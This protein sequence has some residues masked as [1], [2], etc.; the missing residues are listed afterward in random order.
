M[1]K[2]IFFLL[3]LCMVFALTS[4]LAVEDDAVCPVSG[5]AHNYTRADFS[6]PNLKHPTCCEGGYIV[7]VCECGERVTREA[8]AL[9]HKVEDL[10]LESVA[11]T[12]TKDG[13]DKYFCKT[14]GKLVTENKLYAKGHVWGQCHEIEATCCTNGS[15]E[16]R[17]E[18]CDTILEIE[19]L[20]KTGNHADT[21]TE[22]T[23]ATCTA[24][25]REIVKCKEFGT[26]LSDTKL[27]KLGHNYVVTSEGAPTCE[28]E[29]WV[30]S[31]CT[32][33]GD[34]QTILTKRDGHTPEWT[35]TKQPTCTDKG[36]EKLVCT[37]PECKKVLETREL[38][39]LGHDWVLQP[40]GKPA[41]CNK[42]GF[43][44]YVCAVCEARKIDK[45]PML[46]HVYGV[47]HTQDAT[48]TEP[49]FK[50][51][52]CPLCNTEFQ[53]IDLP[54]TE[55]NWQDVI[56]LPA[57]CT[58]DGKKNIVCKDCE[59]VKAVNVTIDKLGHVWNEEAYENE[60]TC[61]EPY[62]KYV[63]C[64]RENCNAINVLE[65]NDPLGH[66]VTWKTIHEP[67][68]SEKGYEEGTCNRCKQLVAGRLIDTVAHNFETI[69]SPATSIEHGADTNICLNCGYR[70]HTLLHFAGEWE[71]VAEP[72][73]TAEGKE[74]RAI[75]V[76]D[77][78][79]ETGS[80]TRAIAKVAHDFAKTEEGTVAPTCTEAGT[81]MFKCA[82]CDATK[83]EPIAATGHTK[84][85]AVV[86]T[87]PTCT[88]KG[89]ETVSCTV[90]KAA[91]STA[92]V[93]ATGHT[94]A[95]DAAVAPTCTETGLT[96][97]AHCSVCKA[98]LTAQAT[99]SALGHTEGE[100]AQTKAPTCTE[101]GVNT[102]SC[103][104]CKAAIKT[105]DV[106][107]LGHTAVADK[108]VAATCTTAGLAA[109]SH[110][111]V[112][113]EVITAQA[114]VDALGHNWTM[115]GIEKATSSQPGIKYYRCSRCNA[116]RTETFGNAVYTRTV[117]A[118]KN[119]NTLTITE[120]MYQEWKAAELTYVYF[121]V[122]N[123]TVCIPVASINVGTL[124]ELKITL[125]NKQLTITSVKNGVVTDLTKD[126]AKM[127][128]VVK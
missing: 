22:T 87:A 9:G 112:C 128:I 78:C 18:V 104:V 125:A 85:E 29:G 17:C 49:G 126:A 102:V 93:A 107:A 32:R 47:W 67:T 16:W 45:I 46:D 36:E 122:D 58:L 103:T 14:T 94:E 48:C 56:T 71:V 6:T 54:I 111:S 121:V 52:Y 31:K 38:D 60:A 25:G 41:A 21:V 124:A 37:K 20:P 79:K 34:V 119:E 10:R 117:T 44:E 101:K 27:D 77:G 68:C 74:A 26:V 39:A 33:C 4:A 70:E 62:I 97:G 57:T 110:C 65:R 95:A 8:E 1:K 24:D 115:S 3:A 127:E 69:H 105:I 40:N 12:C 42:E 99:V 83:S 5:A 109:G 30:E 51:E 15:H 80:Q 61:T 98:V 84:G 53:W 92:D 113:N 50:V 59:E 13:Y 89:V 82:N 28:V 64:Q 76:L 23:K 35:V 96:A 75:C 120:K 11:A 7:M 116:S 118:A 123:T 88:E 43:N 72:T 63:I 91:L 86:T 114:V 106:D 66:D 81:Q 90:C 19:I 108:A 73:C 55:H 100:A 2:V